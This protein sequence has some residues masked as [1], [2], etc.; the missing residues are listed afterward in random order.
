MRTIRLSFLGAIHKIFQL[1]LA[2]YPS[3]HDARLS[4]LVKLY[5]NL[6]YIYMRPT[7]ITLN[8]SV[9]DTTYAR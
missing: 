6:T 3:M 4:W 8:Y 7:A 1:E 5:E 2:S 9:K